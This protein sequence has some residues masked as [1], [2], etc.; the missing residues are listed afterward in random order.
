MTTASTTTV[1]ISNRPP[2]VWE[3]RANLCVFNYR[4]NYKVRRSSNATQAYGLFIEKCWRYVN[5]TVG[6]DTRF[7]FNCDTIIEIIA[8]V[9]TPKSNPLTLAEKP[10]GQNDGFQLA[11]FFV[12][13]FLVHYRPIKFQFIGKQI[14]GSIFQHTNEHPLNTLDR[15]TTSIGLL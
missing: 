7:Y 4:N 13:F 5:V 14:L 2:N 12:G 3:V 11:T 6:R 1:E 9:F 10:Q 8:H 15:N